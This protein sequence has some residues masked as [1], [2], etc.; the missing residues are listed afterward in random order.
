MRR[1][2]LRTAVIVLILANLPTWGIIFFTVDRAKTAIDEEVAA[3]FRAIAENNAATMNYAVN[4][5]VGEVETL[6][7]NSAARNAIAAGNASYQRS[8]EAVR[9]RIASVEQAWLEPQENATV[10]AILSN[11][12]SRYLRRFMTIN[13]A[14]RRITVTDR[15]G[16]GTPVC[17]ASPAPAETPEERIRNFE[18]Y[19]GCRKME[20]AFVPPDGET[21][22]AAEPLR[23]ILAEQGLLSG[24]PV[25]PTRPVLVFVRT[26]KGPPSLHW[27]RLF[28]EW[29]GEEFVMVPKT[30][31][32]WTFPDAKPDELPGM[33]AGTVERFARDYRAENE[34]NCEFE[35]APATGEGK[36]PVKRKILV[37]N[38]GHDG[39]CSMIRRHSQRP[40]AA[41]SAGFH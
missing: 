35:D 30:V 23:K 15:S 28:P 20:F 1:I 2:D 41:G 18:L 34:R 9:R 40:G 3:N 7:A 6:A 12:G 4:D 26:A 33:L 21:A 29:K 27:I 11:P 38:V 32:H 37:E 13:S 24:V 10:H 39:T 14:F 8:P 5:L 19:N 22:R 31:R 17:G 16:L 36:N 25:P